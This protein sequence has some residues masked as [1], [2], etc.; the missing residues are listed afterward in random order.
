M[1]IPQ[2]GTT[3]GHLAENTFAFR[4]TVSLGAGCHAFQIGVDITREQ[5]MTMNP[6]SSAPITS[7]V[8]AHFATTLAASRFGVGVNPLTGGLPNSQRYFRDGAYALFVQDDWKLR[9]NLTV[10]LGLRVGILPPISEKN[11]LMS[12]YIFLAPRASSTA[13][14][15]RCRPS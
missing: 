3:P 2:S 8:L 7:F 12:N 13:R 4:D 1:G 14:C 15:K 11:G 9:P 10:N 5:N 6:V